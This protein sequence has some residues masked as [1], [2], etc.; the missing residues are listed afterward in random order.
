VIFSMDSAKPLANNSQTYVTGSKILIYTGNDASY[1]EVENF[2]DN[3]T[4]AGNIVDVTDSYDFD[5][6]IIDGFDAVLL[7]S[8]GN[9][10]A[11]NLTNLDTW[12]DSG[13]K[14]LW[15]SGDSDYG[16]YYLAN[17]TNPV[18]TAVGTQLR[19]DAGAI[20]DVNVS[21]GS[22]YRVIANATGASS[23]LVDYVTDGFNSTIFN[24]PTSVNW[25]DGT[26]YKDL[27]NK[28]DMTG[29]DI[30]IRSHTTAIALDLDLS[31]GPDDFYAYSD[32]KGGYPMLVTEQVGSSLVVVGG[33]GNYKDYKNMYGTVY[34]ISG[35]P[36]EG[37]MIVDNLFAYWFT[38][39]GSFESV[40]MVVRTVTDIIYSDTVTETETGTITETGTTTE[41]VT[42][43]EPIWEETTVTAIIWN[44]TT[45]TEPVWNDIT[46]TTTIVE[47]QS[48][49]PQLLSFSTPVIL[50][51]LSLLTITIVK[52]R[53]NN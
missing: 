53:K 17:R 13:D 36:H 50:G 41:N 15:V 33:E 3:Y 45:V 37:S 26:Y 22:G 47:I 44:D 34:E 25:Y 9:F 43:T 28:T 23:P 16:G 8:T 24:G 19:L 38:V 30:V 10:T 40:E 1:E 32:I 52:R 6:L 46:V 42:I 20:S 29:I 14:L 35:N 48:N 11:A 27:R 7:P 21:D 12:F 49:N 4:T 31:N 5:D 51:I 39:V 2:Y 18:L